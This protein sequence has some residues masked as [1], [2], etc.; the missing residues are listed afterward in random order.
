MNHGNLSLAGHDYPKIFGKLK[1]LKKGDT[2]YIISKDGRKVDYTVKETLSNVN[3]YDM[4]HIDQNYDGIMKVT[5]ITCE[6]RR[7]YKIFSKGR[8][9]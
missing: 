7:S 4:S 6:P 5:L 9:Y 2:F 8:T 3:P 1:Q